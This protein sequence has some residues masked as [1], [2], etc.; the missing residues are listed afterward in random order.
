MRLI[1]LRQRGGGHR[2]ARPQTYLSYRTVRH[3]CHIGLSDTTV[4]H[5]CHIGMSDTTVRHDC[6]TPTVR[7]RLSDTTVISDYQTRLSYRTV[8]HDYHIGLSDTIVISDCQTQLSYR[9]VRHD[10]HI[11]MS[12]TTVIS[13]CQTQLSYRTVRHDCHIGMSDTTVISECQTQLSDTTVRPRLS[14]PDCQTQLSYRN[15][16]HDCQTRLSDPDCQIPTVRHDCHIGL[17]DTTVIS[18]CQTQLSYQTVRHNCHIGLS[19]T[20]VISDCQT[21]LSYRTVRHNC[22]IGLSDTTVRRDCHIGVSDTTVISDCQ[23]RLSDTTVRRDCHIGMSDTTVISDSQ[24][25]LSYRTVRHDCHIGMSDITVISDCQTQLSYRTV[26]HDCQTRL[27]Y[28]NVRHN[29]HIG[30]SDPTVR[31]DCQT[32]CQTQLSDPR[33]N[34]IDD[35]DIQLVQPVQENGRHPRQA[36]QPADV[37]M[38]A[39]LHFRF[40]MGARQVDL[41][42]GK[43]KKGVADFPLFVIEDGRIKRKELPRDDNF[44]LYS[45]QTTGS[46]FMVRK[47][48]NRAKFIMEGFFYDGLDQLHLTPDPSGALHR[49]HKQAREVDLRDDYINTITTEGVSTESTRAPVGIRSSTRL[50]RQGEGHHDHEIR[51]FMVADYQEYQNWWNYYQKNSTR[52]EIEMNNFYSFIANSINIRYRSISEIDPSFQVDIVVTGLLTVNSPMV[53]TWTEGN[54]L[55]PGSRYVDAYRALEDFGLWVRRR[56]VDLPMSD[57][58]MLFT[59]YDIYTDRNPIVAG[60][61]RLS[62]MCSLSSV[63]II[64]QDYTGS[65]GATAAH[66]LGHSLGSL[67]DGEEI[68][69]LDEDNYV[70][71][72]KLRTPDNDSRA[73]RPWQFSK[74]SVRAFKRFLSKVQCTSKSTQSQSLLETGLN[75]GQIF[76]A[77]K[78][79]SLALGNGSYFARR[80]QYREGYSTMCRRMY[81]SVPRVTGLYQAIFPMERTSCGDRKWCQ[82][83]RCESH[84]DAPSMADNCPQG[85]DPTAP[86]VL[87]D[88][89]LY[90][91]WTKIGFCCHLCRATQ[92]N[93]A[94]NLINSI[95]H[96]NVV[97]KITIGG[98]NDQLKK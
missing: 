54:T 2:Y 50:R 68:D 31:H 81:C 34:P 66:E 29:C 45:N 41:Q 28:R 39:N 8:R 58:W 37:A 90:T 30:V 24:T 49:I 67:H 22:H 61:A 15:V 94:P 62:S 13:E 93:G 84:V 11:G 42:M 56:H 76:S 20:T 3:D 6:Q 32:D 83:G 26:R 72:K 4:R 19:D 92:R 85:D 55:K 40:L 57:H 91:Q 7:S 95:L 1:Y 89:P 46:T 65:V 21:R 80:L 70:M 78:Q 73:S 14:D 88:C 33:I 71:S 63:S 79:C 18:D 77:D 98:G 96:L 86:C 43:N 17:S 97:K 44:Q 51:L 25:R 74:C 75:P 53:S 48:D 82:R 23:T 64:E 59:G 47:S 12:D 27:S 87:E 52:T 60:L 9:T 36:T 10:C 35:V 5:N 69:C 16:R 38:P